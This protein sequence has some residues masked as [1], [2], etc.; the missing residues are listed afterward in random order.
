MVKTQGGDPGDHRLGYN[1]RT[2]VRASDTD[3]EDG[4]INLQ[5]RSTN[6]RG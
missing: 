4:G 2:I 5:G 1:V 6:V 3:F